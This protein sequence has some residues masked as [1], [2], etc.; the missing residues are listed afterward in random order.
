MATNPM[1]EERQVSGTAVVLTVRLVA[2]REELQ[3]ELEALVGPVR[4]QP[5]C[6]HCSLMHDAEGSGVVTLVE[7]WETRADLD[8]HFRSEECRRLLAL[9]EL[10]DAPPEL[11]IDSVAVRE[12][13]EAIAA[14][15]GQAATDD[16]SGI[17][18][19]R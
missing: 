13:M 3:R 9:V 8:R 10:G 11:H 16:F 2:R 1:A 12:G 4:A 15:R 18:D 19:P 6:R 5:G 17:N 14:A 7:E